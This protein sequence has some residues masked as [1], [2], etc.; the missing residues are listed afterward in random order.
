MAGDSR[1]R[2]ANRGSRRVQSAP[3]EPLG[4][5]SG[6]AT[7]PIP[8][9]GRNSALEN[10]RSDITATFLPLAISALVAAVGTTGM[11]HPVLLTQ[12]LVVACGAPCA[13]QLLRP[14]GH[15]LPAGNSRHNP[16]TS[17]SELRR[18]P[19]FPGSD[20]GSLRGAAPAVFVR[21]SKGASPRDALAQDKTGEILSRGGSRT[22]ANGQLCAIPSQ[23]ISSSELSSLHFRIA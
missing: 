10:L 8:E 4:W 18:Y 13:I 7:H 9:A 21:A 14:A 19:L 17:A 2:G 16:T 3:G 23:K 11:V 20:W 5:P 12:M 6:A 1:A 15:V 22:T